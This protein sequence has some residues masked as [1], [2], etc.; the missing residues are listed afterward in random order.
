MIIFYI[1]LGISIGWITMG[2]GVHFVLKYWN[3]IMFDIDEKN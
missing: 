2:I 3:K 1:L